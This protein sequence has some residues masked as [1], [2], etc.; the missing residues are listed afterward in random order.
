MQTISISMSV[1]TDM[2]RQI[3][4]HGKTCVRSREIAKYF[5]R[6]GYNVRESRKGYVITE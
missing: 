2:T 5:I 1:L 6:H 3:D 4:L